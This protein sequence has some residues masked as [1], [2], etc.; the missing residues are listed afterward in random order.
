V[1]R[2]WA[3]ARTTLREAV[4]TR[5][6]LVILIT[7][8]GI[9]V[10]G[11]FLLRGTGKLADRV[12][13]VL[14][15]SLSAIG[16]LLS[17]LT[18]FLSASSLSGDVREK[19]VETIVTKPVPRWQIL[20]GKWCGVML[21][22]VALVAVSG[23]LSYGLVRHVIGRPA[24]AQ[25]DQERTQLTNEVYVARHTVD[26]TTP[27]FEAHIEQEVR[28]RTLADAMPEDVT[29]HEF[30]KRLRTRQLTR[31]RSLA[32]GQRRGRL[33]ER[34]MP[35]AR[36]ETLFLR[37]KVITGGSKEER[38]ADNTVQLHWVFS[39]TP[40]PGSPDRIDLLTKET[41]GDF[42][43][44]PIPA[45]VAGPGGQVFV[46]C[47]NIDQRLVYA[48]FP[49]EEGVQILYRAGTFEGNFVRTMLLLLVRLAFLSALALAAAAFL[50]FPVASL[51][52]LFIF[53]CALSVNSFTALASPVGGTEEMPVYQ[54]PAFYRVVL[55]AVSAVVPN[56][57]LYD[58]AGELATGRLVAWRLVGR[59]F[60]VV[61]AIYGGLVMA[62]GCLYFRSC[63]LALAESSG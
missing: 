61:G 41:M 32:P 13:L 15:Y 63:E 29:E 31:Y 43:E 27:D 4:R 3:I 60:L 44:I 17:L 14:T 52:V 10:L 45:R 23:A 35:A 55:K 20:V 47:M 33:F 56:F 18:I 9:V 6:A 49:G 26:P 8:V 57:G 54:A 36:E 34:V 25:T 59:G 46:A 30:R 48:A 19:R 50:S 37:Y 28:A 22:N 5:T 7:L 58:G 53:M 21:L 1:R 24:A 40:E 16:F 51:F 12:Q 11:P 2:L 42:H 38:P 62:L 39:P